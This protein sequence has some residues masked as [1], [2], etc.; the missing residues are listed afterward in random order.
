MWIRANCPSSVRSMIPSFAVPYNFLVVALLL[1]LTATKNSLFSVSA[2]TSLVPVDLN[3]IKNCVREEEENS[4]KRYRKKT[5]KLFILDFGDP[6]LEIFNILSAHDMKRIQNLASCVE[7]HS[8]MLFED[9]KFMENG[10]LVHGGSNVTYLTGTLQAVLPDVT[11]KIIDGISAGLKQSKWRETAIENLGIRTVQ[12]VYC[13]GPKRLKT[14]AEIQR[15]KEIAIEKS[16]VL[17]IGGPAEPEDPE[18]VALRDAQADEF[19]AEYMSPADHSVYTLALLLTDR[20]KFMGGNIVIRKAR[21]EDKKDSKKSQGGIDE[22]DMDEEMEGTGY[23]DEDE[24]EEQRLHEEM[25]WEKKRQEDKAKEDE[26]RKKKEK[27]EEEKKRKKRKGIFRGQQSDNTEDEESNEGD[28][29]N[30]PLKNRKVPKVPFDAV[31]TGIARYTPERGGGIL[32]KSYHQHG[33]HTVTHGRRVALMIEFWPY[34]DGA[35]GH[36][37]PSIGDALPLNIPIGDEL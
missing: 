5:D 22:G 17:T 19:V 6:A 30:D 14:A 10:H 26:A 15:E 8:P 9:N 20:S 34:R 28:N 32:M 25:M 4:D 31:T 12:Y 2:A 27:E 37:K 36:K 21:T 18:V 1:T 7:K 23:E 3:E 11:K 29:N 35:V 13:R 24:D 16:K 33:T